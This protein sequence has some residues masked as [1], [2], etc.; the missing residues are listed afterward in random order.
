MTI[1]TSIKTP[2]V[3]ARRSLCHVILLKDVSQ[4]ILEFMGLIEIYIN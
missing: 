4:V 2:L 3:W 1:D